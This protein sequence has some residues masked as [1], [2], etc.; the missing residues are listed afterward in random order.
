MACTGRQRALVLQGL[1]GAGTDSAGFRCRR[2]GVDSETATDAARAVE[3]L[4]RPRSACRAPDRVSLTVDRLLGIYLDS[5][6]AD[7]RL[8]AKALRLPRR[9]KACV[10]PWL[11]DKC[12]LT[13]G[14]A[15]RR[16]VG[17]PEQPQ[18]TAGEL[19][20]RLI[21]WRMLGSS[22]SLA[23][24][25][26]RALE[27]NGQRQP[28]G[29]PGDP[30]AGT[31]IARVL[32]SQSDRLCPMWA[33]LVPWPESPRIGELICAVARHRLYPRQH[34]RVIGS[35]RLSVGKSWNREES[36]T[37]VRTIDLGA[38]LVAVL[39]QQRGDAAVRGPT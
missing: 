25:L 8:S 30:D 2:R 37:A 35:Q 17:S 1:V 32:R 4:G 22:H 14:A 36:A 28:P 16:S 39:E 20:T 15:I 33:F 24:L 5:L 11:G 23:I 31:A 26:G 27:P 18:G 38:G 3:H 7:E 10:R 12:S 6:D 19:S 9:F 34:A 29:R 21:D 13:V